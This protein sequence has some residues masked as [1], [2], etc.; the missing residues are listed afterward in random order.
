MQ[1]R[2]VKNNHNILYMMKLHFLYLTL[3]GI[4][5]IVGDAIY[6]CCMSYKQMMILTPPP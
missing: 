5:D 6:S 2:C 3:F 1:V 4:G